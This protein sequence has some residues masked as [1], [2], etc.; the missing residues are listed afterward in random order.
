VVDAVK[1]KVVEVEPSGT[2]TLEGKEDRT[3]MGF[4]IVRVYPPGPA[5][6]VKVSVPVPVSP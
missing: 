6:S 3:E 5:T 4:V 2:V 1:V